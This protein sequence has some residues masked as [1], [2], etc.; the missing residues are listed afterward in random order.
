MHPETLKE[1]GAFAVE[2]GMPVESKIAKTYSDKTQRI[3]IVLI[4]ATL[5]IT[6]MFQGSTYFQP[7]NAEDFGLGQLIEIY[8]ETVGTTN[9]T[10][11]D[12]AYDEFVDRMKDY[13][14]PLIEIT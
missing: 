6:P 4:L 13:D 9:A 7:L 1:A 14:Y 2:E 5:F 10:V 8:K 3:L 11:Y 12:T